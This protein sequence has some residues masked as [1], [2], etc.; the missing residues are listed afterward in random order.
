MTVQE[1]IE[2][3]EQYD[4]TALVV[5]SSDPEGNSYSPIEDIEEGFFDTKESTY[6]SEEEF[7]GVTPED[8]YIEDDEDSVKKPHGVPCV[9]IWPRY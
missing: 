4:P 3:L 1:L 8:E 6:Y 7:L 5:I 2:M 9:A